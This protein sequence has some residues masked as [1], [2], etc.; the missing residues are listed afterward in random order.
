MRTSGILIQK[1]YHVRTG[2]KLAGIIAQ[3]DTLSLMA[4]RQLGCDFCAV[5][6]RTA[7]NRTLIPVS[8]QHGSHLSIRNLELLEKAW[9]EAEVEKTPPERGLRDLPARASAADAFGAANGFACRY[10]LPVHE[11]GRLCAVVIGYWF[12]R[13]GAIAGEAERMLDLVGSVLRAA[14]SIADQLLVVENYSTRLSELLPV[15]EAPLEETKFS[16]LV[17]ATLGRAARICPT[18]YVVLLARDRRTGR[19]G[20]AESYGDRK[21]S[22]ELCDFI[23]RAAEPLTQVEAAGDEDDTRRFRCRDL[24]RADTL[25]LTDL[26]VLPV[27]PGDELYYLLAVGATGEH[28]LS[29]NDREL[30]SVFAVFA[31]T[32]LRNA[33]LFRRLQ[34][35][36]R[37]LERSSDRLADAEAMAALTDLTSGVAHD[38]NNIF[39]G[40]MGRVQLLRLRARE[41]PQF[42]DELAKVERLVAEG[43][44]TVRRLQEF[45]TSGRAKDVQ[46][47]DLVALVQKTLQPAQARWREL[48]VSKSIRIE[49]RPETEAA[50]I[51]GCAEDL[52]TVLRKLLENAV[53]HAPEGSTVAVALAADASDY[54]LQVCD[55]G[56][57][58]PPEAGKKIFYPFFTT[59][60]ERGAG[61][62][63]AIVHG[64]VSRH[65]GKVGYECTPDAGTVFTAAF[66]RPATVAEISEV[67]TR[68]K[69]SA[70]GLR[71]LV[72]DDDDQIREVLR[73]MLVIAGHQ[74]VA[75]ANGFEALETVNREPFDIMITDLGMPGM[76]GLD[77][78]GAVHEQAPKMPIAMITGWGTQLDQREIAAKGVR[79]VLSKPF[80][81]KD[82]RALVDELAGA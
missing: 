69:A 44:E 33:L 22:S 81:L 7:G 24:A 38:F 47:V 10:L 45:A 75:C 39:G 34:R 63:L 61:L 56:K 52:A 35:A 74:A 59:K 64:I 82:I 58:I 53:E 67:T 78:A 19:I 4:A 60:T 40:I 37:L 13:P 21:P 23:L 31:Q 6:Y 57:G 77:L 49:F 79:A 51:E 42:N 80:H 8:Y 48:A 30:L 72:V 26:V 46:P 12:E 68:R 55:R 25:G 27:A 41:L 29:A 1:Y 5:F 73:D 32:V 54:R 17:S 66:K 18:A 43:A 11:D 50:V 14:L 16:A 36:N 20:C 62:G 3:V 2:H 71:I 70:A 15:F 28:G 76:S 65:G 9:G